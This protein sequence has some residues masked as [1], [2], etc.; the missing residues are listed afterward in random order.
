MRVPIFN[1]EGLSGYT[2]VSEEDEEL[3]NRYRWNLTPNGYVATKEKKKT[4][5]LH[6]V[7]IR[8]KAGE[9]VDH[10]NGVKTDNRRENLR[11]V[12]SVQNQANRRVSLKKAAGKY[13]GVFRHRDKWK[14]Q[15]RSNG[16]G[17]YLGVFEDQEEAGRAYDD[18]AVK[19]WGKYAKLNFGGTK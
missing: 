18:M 2:E 15:I 12:N 9:M 17:I 3:A 19:L 11:I 13:K 6:R 1:R 8:A 10:I 5:Y 7:V 16:V 14:V 4:V